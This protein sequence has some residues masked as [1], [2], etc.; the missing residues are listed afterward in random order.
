V[1]IFQISLER[2]DRALAR[3]EGGVARGPERPWS[4][5]VF[6]RTTFSSVSFILAV[7]TRGVSCRV[8]VDGGTC[9]E[10]DARSLRGRGGELGNLK[11]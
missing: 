1:S 7:E 3:L 8:Y 9:M 5:W 4:S 10:S 2:S 6:L 11:P